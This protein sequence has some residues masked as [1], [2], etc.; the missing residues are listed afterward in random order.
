MFPVL[1]IA[2]IFH[3]FQSF[4]ILAVFIDVSNIIHNGCEIDFKSSTSSLAPI[5][6]G[7]GDLFIFTLFNA[8]NILLSVTVNPSI[9]VLVSTLGIA[10]I[11][12]GS[13]VEIREFS[14]FPYFHL[15]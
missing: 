15:N 10:G 1:Y 7:P 12:P 9:I 2:E 4:G 6:S 3:Y 8:N 14:A 5:S 13:S 11:F